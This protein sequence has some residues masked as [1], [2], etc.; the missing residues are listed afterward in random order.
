M[1][2]DAEG[3]RQERASRLTE[4]GACFCRKSSITKENW[5][6]SAFHELS[7]WTV[8]SPIVFTPPLAF[9]LYPFSRDDFTLQSKPALLL[10]AEH[11]P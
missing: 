10:V 3:K 6:F 5:T 7:L 11:L 4:G 8:L 9:Y 1:V 2:D